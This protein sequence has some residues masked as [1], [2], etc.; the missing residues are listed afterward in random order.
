HENN[1]IEIVL[2]IFNNPNKRNF[3]TQ[4]IFKKDSYYSVDDKII[5]K[6]YKGK[7]RPK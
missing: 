6:I 7:K 3:K 4:A 2:F 5:P 1:I